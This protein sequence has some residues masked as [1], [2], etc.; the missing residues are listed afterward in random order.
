[1][2][3]RA[4]HTE[5][6]A[7]RFLAAYP[8]GIEHSYWHV[9]RN[10]I[11]HRTMARHLPRDARVLEVGCG[12]GVVTRHLR[13]RGWD[14][15]GVDLGV[16]ADHGAGEPYLHLGADALT[17]PDDLRNSITALALFDVIEHVPDAP[18]FLQSLLGAYPNVR[19]VVI[20]V[21]AGM[22]LWSDFDDHYGHYRRYDR[23][24]I[25]DELARSGIAPLQHRYFFHALALAIRVNNMLFAR[26]RQ[27]EF[28]APR[29]GASRLLNR[30]LGGLFS[31]E[32]QLL[33]GAMPGSS[34][35]AVGKR[36]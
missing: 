36:Q 5:F 29:P 15:T 8:P 32:E 24:M 28:K 7:D 13:A 21:P 16:P 27:L 9:A 19:H 25:T 10:R 31:L 6:D 26:K 14:C 23:R 20:T 2:E 34:I 12:T 22:R 35:I 33:P 30:L 4:A 1:M 17:L 18:G 11:I 3:Q